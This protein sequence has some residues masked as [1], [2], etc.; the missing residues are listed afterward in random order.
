MVDPQLTPEQLER[1]EA[2][3]KKFNAEL[4]KTK[5]LTEEIFKGNDDITK[6]LLKN[7]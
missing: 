6:E 4:V 3:Q 1:L 7:S 2:Q 5:I